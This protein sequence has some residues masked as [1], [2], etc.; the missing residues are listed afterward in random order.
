M[1]K[2]VTM[3]NMIQFPASQTAINSKYGFI[4][5]EGSL[6]SSSNFSDMFSTLLSD[7]NSLPNSNSIIDTSNDLISPWLTMMFTK[8]LGDDSVS[9]PNTSKSPLG[10]PVNG[11]LTQTSHSGHVALDFGVAVGTNVKSTMDGK[12]TFAG[13]NNEG[14]GNLVIV[15]N[16]MYKTYYA[17]LS[18]IPVNVGQTV[19]KGETVGLSGNTGN[20][21]G[22]HLHYEVR[23]NGVAIN[24]LTTISG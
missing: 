24:P 6:L 10:N 9:T 21:T 11:V 19:R 18:S 2:L 7:M 4:S 22:P 23:K 8:L 20:S 14:Y 16:G 3:T 5:K 15:D 13:W 12:V 17:H 1:F